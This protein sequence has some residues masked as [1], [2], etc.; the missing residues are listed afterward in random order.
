MGAA[1]GQDRQQV[2]AGAV[3]DGGGHDVAVVLG[4]F[5]AGD[6]VDDAGVPGV[7]R[8][9]HALG[10]PGG[11]AGELDGLGGVAR[12]RVPHRRA[13]GVAGQQGVQGQRRRAVF[14]VDAMAAL[15]LG[16]QGR[17]HAV[18]DH[19]GRLGGL[20]DAPDL[21]LGAAVVQRH[22]DLAA[23]QHGQQRQDVPRGIAGADRHAGLR[24]RVQLL[25]RG[26]Q[27]AHFGGQPGIRRLALGAVQ[28]DAVR[29][30]F[31]GAEE[32]IDRV[33][34]CSLVLIRPSWP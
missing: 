31:G 9:H 1:L 14:Q 33:H 20:Q 10:Q 28:R 19:D 21:A 17:A 32:E 30:A 23:G 22:P 2:G 18:H 8:L 5:P 15:G 7:V 24:R 27:G 4:Q 16:R 3:R 13:S 26:R 6:L 29:M 25:Q 34:L 12:Q 11:A